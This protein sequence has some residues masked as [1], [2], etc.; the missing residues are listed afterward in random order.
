MDRQKSVEEIEAEENL[1]NSK[2]TI[3]PAATQDRLQDDLVKAQV[4]ATNSVPVVQT[5]PKPKKTK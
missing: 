2:Y 5:E 1:A 4:K 3:L